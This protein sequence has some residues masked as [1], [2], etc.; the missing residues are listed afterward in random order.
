MKQLKRLQGIEWHDMKD[1]LKLVSYNMNKTGHVKGIY[2]DPETNIK[3][4]HWLN[5]LEITDLLEK[6]RK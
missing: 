4:T 6:E 2:K 5:D 1:K 3:Y